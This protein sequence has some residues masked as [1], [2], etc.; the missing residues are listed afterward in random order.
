VGGDVLV[1]PA[2]PLELRRLGSVSSTPEKH[3]ADFLFFGKQVGMVGVQRKEINDLIASI[4]DDRLTRE[5]PLLQR[6]DVGVVLIEGRIEWT[7]DG[8]LLAAS[9]QFTK[10]QYL[11]T[12]W[13]LQS[14]GLWTSFTDSQTETIRYLSLFSRWI[15]KEKHTGLVRRSQKAARNE[16]GIKDDRAWQIFVM[17]SFPGIG[18]ERAKAIVDHYGGLPLAWTGKLEEV[19]GIGKQTAQRLGR[20]L[21]AREPDRGSGVTSGS[22]GTAGDAVGYGGAAV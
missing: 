10:A 7:N 5:I 20:M 18:Y 2:E 17:Q 16:Y 3:G 11:G 1:S 4:N 9:S 21:T 19:D 22:G 13:S 15:Q 6:L 8:F 14:L 12:L